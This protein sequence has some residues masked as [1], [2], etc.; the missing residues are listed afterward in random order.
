MSVN[1]LYFLKF[2]SYKLFSQHIGNPGVLLIDIEQLTRNTG[3]I[4][5]IDFSVLQTR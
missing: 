4:F 3:T 2:L 5:I 1:S